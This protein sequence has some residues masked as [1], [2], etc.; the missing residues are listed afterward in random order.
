MHDSVRI[1]ETRC[2]NCGHLLN[3]LGTGDVTVEAQPKPGD[4]IVCIKCGAVMLVG[5]NLTLRGMT[6]AE[7]DALVSDREWMDEVAR[8]VQ[9]V[10]FVRHISN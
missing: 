5:N 10:H 3:A 8:M 1:P 7:M 9:K 2:L 6:D 4:A